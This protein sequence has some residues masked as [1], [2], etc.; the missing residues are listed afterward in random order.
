MEM[1]VR[2]FVRGQQCSHKSAL[3]CCHGKREA[4]ALFANA[5]VPFEFSSTRR[6]RIQ[7][8]FRLGQQSC[9]ICTVLKSSWILLDCWAHAS[10]TNG[11]FGKR[12]REQ[13]LGVEEQL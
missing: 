8:R 12:V 4:H 6:I 9:L 1:S 10:Q 2:Q 7:A 11:A 13:M 5:Q 3:F